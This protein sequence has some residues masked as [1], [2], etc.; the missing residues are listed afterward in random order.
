MSH[1]IFISYNRIDYFFGSSGKCEQLFTKKC[2]HDLF[3]IRGVS[4]LI[5][6]NSSK[7]IDKKSF[8]II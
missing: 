6:L 4:G 1:L 8:K 2:D 3:D 7:F 5:G